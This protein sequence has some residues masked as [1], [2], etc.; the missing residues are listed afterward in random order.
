MLH[1]RKMI[2]LK[3]RGMSLLLMKRS[4]KKDNP[5][6]HWTPNTFRGGTYYNFQKR[7][8]KGHTRDNLKQVNVIGFDLDTKEVDL[9]ALYL[10]L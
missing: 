9:Y 7:I 2:W 5:L 6:S 1:H 10:G 8:I 3:G 4:M